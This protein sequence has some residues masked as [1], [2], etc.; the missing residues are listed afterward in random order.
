MNTKVFFTILAIVGVGAVSCWWVLYGKTITNASA[1][2]SA[3]ATAEA[4][5]VAASQ[6]E[7]LAAFLATSS[8]TATTVLGGVVPAEGSVPFIGMI[9]GLAK[10]A[11]V[12][13]TVQSVGLGNPSALAPAASASA[14]DALTLS[15]SVQGTWSAVYRFL[16]MLETLPYKTQ[17]SAVS[18]NQSAFSVPGTGGKSGSPQSFWSGS[19][20]LAVLKNLSPEDSV[21]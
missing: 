11:N 20:S 7:S 9:E 16:N 4:A 13:L 15:L 3:T 1:A 21:K 10:S 19:L 5:N 14:F 6:D 18:L 17:I 2:S 12:G 8:S